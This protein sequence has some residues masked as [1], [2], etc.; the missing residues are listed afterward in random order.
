MT[1]RTVL[2]CGNADIEI[3]YDYKKG[4]E[5]SILFIHGLGACKE[6]FKDALDFLGY[7]KYSIVTPDLPGFGDSGKA[8]D[9]ACTMKDYSAICRVL[10]ESL[11]MKRVHIVAH[12]MGGAVGLLLADEIPEKVLSY[13]S[14]E[15][16][17]IAED[18][19]LSKKTI[20][21][22]L[23]EFTDNGFKKLRAG[24][25]RSIDMSVANSNSMVLF[26]DWLAKSDPVAFYKCSESLVTLSTSGELLEMFQQFNKNKCYIYGEMNR[27]MPVIEQLDMIPKLM[28][29]NAGHSMMTDNPT[30][31]YQKLLMVLQQ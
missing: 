14:L 2:S 4:G 25:K 10:I 7:E 6:C 21:R 18:C 27:N 8:E 12:S 9:F 28:I 3:A 5:E 16:N 20:S 11:D 31:F 26:N 30:E 1:E 15:G 23:L 24:M 29:E 19:W 17:L 22:S 13:I